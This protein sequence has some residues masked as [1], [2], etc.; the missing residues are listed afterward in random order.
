MANN[1]K[2]S[3][4]ALASLDTIPLSTT[5]AITVTAT[6]GKS[7]FTLSAEITSDFGKGSWIWD[8]GNSE[9]YRVDRMKT[10]SVTEGF[11]VGTFNYTLSG[12]DD[13]DYIKAEDAKVV[14]MSIV[15]DVATTV[16]GVALGVGESLNY[17]SVNLGGDVGTRYVDPVIV[18]GATGAVRYMLTK[19]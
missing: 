18:D 10:G 8:K 4:L 17:T 1:K 6:S 12:A 15:A 13:I 5:T 11:I 16:D 19:F 14:Q 9:L 3:F 7:A 2:E